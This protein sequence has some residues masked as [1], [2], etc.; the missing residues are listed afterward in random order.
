MIGFWS[1]GKLLLPVL[2]CSSLLSA[3]DGG[4][5]SSKTRPINSSGTIETLDSITVSGIRYET[6]GATVDINGEAASISQLKEGQYVALNGIASASALNGIA[7]HVDY[8]AHLIGP[9]ESIEASLGRL[10]VMGQ[11]VLTDS[12]T[13]VGPGVELVSFSGLDTGSVVQISGFLNTSDQLLATRIDVD[14]TSTGAQVAGRVSSLDLSEMTFKIN[15][16]LLDYSGASR[17][18]IPSGTPADGMTVLA[19][20]ILS[21]DT[22]MV[23]E[24]LARNDAASKTPGQRNRLQGLITGISSPV[25]ITLNHL[26]VILGQNTSYQNGTR[27]DLRTNE[28]IVVDGET[29]S[30]GLSI[31]AAEIS[32]DRTVEE[33]ETVTYEFKDFTDIVIASVFEVEVTQSS[34]FLVEVTIDRDAVSSLAVMQN[35]STINLGLQPAGTNVRTIK[36]LVTLPQLNRIETE[37]VIGVTLSGFEQS[38]LIMNIS[39]SSRLRGDSL[40]LSTLTATVSGISEMDFGEINPVGSATIDINGLSNATLNMAVGSTLS[41]SVTSTLSRLFYYGTDVTVDVSADAISSIV[42]LGE[43]R[44]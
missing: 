19:R 32:F 40:T 12:D 27:N 24:L 22:L 43:T 42:K 2:L 4:S 23:D 9:V 1:N 3:C 37:G 16:L 11:T 8:E 44:F 41:G 34:D 28:K 21:D 18:D 17:I 14:A 7:E 26:P 36:A 5:S 39:G 30:D 29:A 13:A 35:G 6:D 25:D 10:I 33:T 31:L 38:G 20:G 15:R